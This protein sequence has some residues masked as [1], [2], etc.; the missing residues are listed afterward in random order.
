MFAM[1]WV[2][3]L[4]VYSLSFETAERVWDIFLFEGTKGAI[5]WLFQVSVAIFQLTKGLFSP[6]FA[7]LSFPILTFSLFR[8]SAV[9]V[10]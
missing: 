9:V 10:A 1:D 6:P 8:S 3:T 2:T 5:Q 4:F 7:F